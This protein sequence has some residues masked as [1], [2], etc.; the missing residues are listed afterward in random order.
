MHYKD[1]VVYGGNK[2]YVSTNNTPDR[3]WE[4]MIF[5]YSKDGNIDWGELHSRLHPNEE[6]AKQHHTE[7]VSNIADY[8]EDK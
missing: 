2:Y 8:L 6:S 7:V 5:K 1:D 4:T 3:G